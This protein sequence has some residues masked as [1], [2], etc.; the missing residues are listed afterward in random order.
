MNEI[1]DSLL[2]KRY[3]QGDAG[4][5]DRLYERFRL[6]VFNYIIRQVGEQAVAEDIFQDV[7]FRVI[8]ALE[9]F[10]A[11]SHFPGWLF[12]IAHNRLVD[13]WR[14][15]GKWPMEALPDEQEVRQSLTQDIRQFLQDCVDRLKQLIGLLNPDQRDAFLLQ[16]ESGLSLEQIAEVT[17]TSRETVKSRLRYA[18]N[19]LRDGLQDCDESTGDS[20]GR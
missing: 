9:G 19:R 17:G 5:F 7:W 10:D 16:Q 20:H 13:H 8:R 15:S 2:I 12:R 4:A 3:L 11:E 1:A 6:P 14:Q 18:V